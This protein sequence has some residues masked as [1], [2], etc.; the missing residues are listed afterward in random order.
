MSEDVSVLLTDAYQHAAISTHE[1]VHFSALL[2]STRY[3][4]TTTGPRRCQ[5]ASQFSCPRSHGEVCSSRP[6]ESVL[7]CHSVKRHLEQKEK[8][9]TCDA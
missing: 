8:K 1:T 4:N 9:E 5:V 3:S 7:A 2:G 6:L